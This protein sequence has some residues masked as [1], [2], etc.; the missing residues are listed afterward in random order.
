MC[1]VL[2]MICLALLTGCKVGKNVKNVPAAVTP[3]GVSGWAEVDGTRY[4][5]EILTATDSSI[6][7]LAAPRQRLLEIPAARIKRLDFR[8]FLS[9]DETLQAA[10]L[11]QLRNASRFPYGIPENALAALL[12]HYNQQAIERID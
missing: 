10:D 6:V 3:A 5:G 2:I 11:A 12:A 4:Q 1:R 8:P 9:H 7:L